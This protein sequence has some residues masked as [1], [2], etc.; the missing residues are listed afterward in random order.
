MII[1]N[2]NV[3]YDGQFHDVDIR[4][5]GEKIIEIGPNLEYDDVYDAKGKYIFAGFIDTHIH[6]ACQ[7]NCGDSVASMKEI[8][9]V[10]PQ[11]GVTSFIPTPIADTPEHS[12]PLVRNIRAAKGCPGTDILGMFLYTAYKNRSIPYYD[13]PVKP[14]K[15][16]TLALA[17][18]DLS[19]IRAVLIAPELTG[20]QE[21]I[22]WLVS[23]GILPVIG[24]SEGKPKDI[25]EAV[26]RGA[27]LTDHF[28]NGF[29]AI[30]HHVSQAVVQ[31]L[32]E[33]DLYFQLNPDCIHVAPEFI[34]MM[35]R[36]K[37]TKHIVAVSDSSPLL[38]KPEG[39]YMMGNKT[40]ILKD[41][42]VRDIHGKLVTGA[43][44]YDENMRTLYAHGFSLETIGSIF[45]EN[46]ARVFQLADRGKLE[47]GRRAD[48]VVMDAGLHV[49]KTMILGKWFYEAGEEK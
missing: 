9:A 35:L 22:S 37:G 10:L 45:T 31:C 38:G 7:V 46:A 16:G 40:V 26:K 17:D 43:H 20:G 44:T 15:E 34:E 5:G 32:L 6:G 42:A 47:A 41:G 29:P 39:K 28:P 21:W 49:S 23:K 14:T 2:G 13:P 25:Q 24:F 1:K 48:I 36:L 19:D 18:G 3:F 11:Y 30:D 33:K 12:V 4:I 27:V 8:C